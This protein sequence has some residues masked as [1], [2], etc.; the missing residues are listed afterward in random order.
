MELTWF[1]LGCF[2]ITERS[3]STVVT[4]PFTQKSGLGAPKIKGD[5]VTISHIGNGTSRY[6]EENVT[7]LKQ[8]L[9]GP[10]EYELGGV[11]IHGIAA[12]RKTVEE[13]RNIIF[14][15][16]F[17]GLKVAHLGELDK[18]PTQT[19]IDS[20]GGVDILLL[21][22]GGND[23][24]NASQASEVVS[25]IEPAIVIPTMYAEDGLKYEYDPLDKFVREMGITEVS[26]ESSLKISR[27]S[28]P[29][30]PQVVF[31]EPKR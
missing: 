17:D 1:G 18:V 30:E 4:D 26:A 29:E 28:L 11:F 14:V 16:N 24:L 8:K 19:Q 21:P 31:L 12:P 15:Y 2:R 10:G 20:L 9:D 3:M 25:M 22:V 23:V 13:K 6:S 5:I 27:S 7:G